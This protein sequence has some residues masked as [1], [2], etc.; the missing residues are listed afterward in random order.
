LLSFISLFIA[1]DAI[2]VM[3]MFVGLTSELEQK[4]KTRI[5]LQSVLTAASCCFNGLE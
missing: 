2:G 5:V 3:P 4:A 1:T